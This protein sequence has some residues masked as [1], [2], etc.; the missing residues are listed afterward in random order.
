MKEILYVTHVFPPQ[1]GGGIRRIVNTVKIMARETFDVTVLTRKI[2]KDTLR[3]ASIP[4]DSQSLHGLDREKKLSIVRAYS[5][6]EIYY[7]YLKGNV[8]RATT[9]FQVRTARSLRDTAL[10]WAPFAV[11]TGMFISTD[12]IFTTGPTFINFLVTFV[13]ARLKRVPYMLEYRDGWLLDPSIETPKRIAWMIKLQESLYL[14]HAKKIITVTNGMKKRLQEFYGVKPE[15]IHVIRNGYW[16]DEKERVLGNPKLMLG[17][18]FSEQYYN[19]AH[20]GI[21]NTGRGPE[22]FF[23]S[24]SS[25]H[26][27]GKKPYKVHFIGTTGSDR[28]YIYNLA[29]KH[30]IRQAVQCHEFVSRDESLAYMANSDALLLL[31]NADLKDKGGFGVPG[32]LGDYVMM[33]SK[34]LIDASLIDFLKEEL[35]LKDD[36]IAL[37]DSGIENFVYLCDCTG[38][39][40][41]YKDFS[42]LAKKLKL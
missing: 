10:L 1:A 30:G 25:L 18:D 16:I 27:I 33:N 40:D 4:T 37:R 12:G 13:L 9:Q 15:R 5:L 22:K 20:V 23:R 17:S 2:G 19:I 26:A 42:I 14:K 6:E 29:D 31:I 35:G 36:D 21:L 28:C 34:I 3:K 8:K 39:L 11:L 38:Q 41:F 32:K 24:I 7:K